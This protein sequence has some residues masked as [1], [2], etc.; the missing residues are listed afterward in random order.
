VILEQEGCGGC[1]SATGFVGGRAATQLIVQLGEVNMSDHPEIQY[2]PFSAVFARV[3][4]MVFGSLILLITAITVASGT[5]QNIYAAG[6]IY[7]L[8]VFCMIIVRYLDI[9][10]LR[11]ETVDCRPATWRDW[12]RYTVFLLITS[13]AIWALIWTVRSIYPA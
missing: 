11:G 5:F 13:A 1:Y 8:D 3:Y 6:V 2:T 12:K 4:W 10:Y 7:W 9:R